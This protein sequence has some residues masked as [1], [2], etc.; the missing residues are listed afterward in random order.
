M[1]FSLSTAL[2][3]AACIDSAAAINIAFYNTR[4]CASGTAEFVCVNVA[5][6]QCCDPRGRSFNSMEFQQVSTSQNIELR[7]Y[8][9]GGCTTRSGTSSSRGRSTICFVREPPYTGA[10]YGNNVRRR[11]ETDEGDDTAD[12]ECMRPQ[13]LAFADGARFNLTSLSDDEYDSM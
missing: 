3:A 9:G 5:R 6:N 8:R 2:I 12:E 13:E 7:S 4:N 1:K 11:D 10:G